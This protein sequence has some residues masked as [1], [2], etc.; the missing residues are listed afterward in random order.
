MTQKF[1]E[2]GTVVPVT[3]VKAGPCTVTQVKKADKDGYTAVQVGYGQTKNLVKALQGHLKGLPAHRWLREF[4]L[5]KTDG[6]ERGKEIDVTTFQVGDVVKVTGQS[7]GKGF[8]G[9]VKRHKFHGSPATHG[10]KD[11]LRM[12]GSIGAGEPQHVFK[13]TRMAGHMGNDQVTE[14]NLKIVEV[15]AEKNLLYIKGAVPGARHGFLLIQGEGELVLKR[16]EELKSERTEEL[17]TEEQK[18]ES[19]EE[20]KN[21]KTEEPKTEELKNEST[22]EPKN[23]G[24]EEVKKEEDKK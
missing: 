8:Q 12:P 9:V 5:E 11:Q 13:G 6:L 24:T 4:R 17:K 20:L 19:T 21:V 10:H 18:N 14:M 7:K 1:L 15:D 3:V 22:E 16:A 2:D 23:V